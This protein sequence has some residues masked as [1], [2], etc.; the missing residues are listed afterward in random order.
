MQVYPDGGYTQHHYP[1]A[2]EDYFCMDDYHYNNAFPH[3]NMQ[4]R[5]DQYLPLP[6]QNGMRDYYYNNGPSM[7][8]N[9]DQWNPPQNHYYN[10]MDG[11]GGYD[12]KSDNFK[13]GREDYSAQYPQVWCGKE[14]QYYTLNSRNG[15]PGH[16]KHH[17]GYKYPGSMCRDAEMSGGYGAHQ[18]SCVPLNEHRLSYSEQNKAPPVWCPKGIL[19]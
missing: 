4:M 5:P 8:M 16:G 2:D 1:V 10:H 7:Q 6:K 17:N 3:Q 13:H 18:G 11:Y 9:P 15:Y 12:Q 19:D 14:Q